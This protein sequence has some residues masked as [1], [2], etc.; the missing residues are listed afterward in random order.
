MTD[1]QRA[2]DYIIHLDVSHRDRVILKLSGVFTD[3]EMAMRH[4]SDLLVGVDWANILKVH[5]YQHGA[6]DPNCTDFLTLDDVRMHWTIGP[7]SL[8]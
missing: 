1:R 4:A 5:G 8:L 7:R 2:G 3:A 6:G